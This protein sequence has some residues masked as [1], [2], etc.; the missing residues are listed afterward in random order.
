MFFMFAHVKVYWRFLYVYKKVY[1]EREY[2][3]M[4]RKEHPIENQ[5]LLFNC[6][7]LDKF[8]PTWKITSLECY[9]NS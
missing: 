1:K 8:H 6:M 7:I 2:S 4:G 9:K 3:V 5:E